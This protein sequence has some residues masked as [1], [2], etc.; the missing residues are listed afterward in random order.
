MRVDN[1]SS[2]PIIKIN[3]KNAYI[4]SNK[5]HTL[6]KS[7]HLNKKKELC[8]FGAKAWNWKY[9]KLHICEQWMWHSDINLQKGYK[10]LFV[11]THDHRIHIYIHKNVCPGRL[12]N[13]HQIP[14]KKGH[15]DHS[16]TKN[17]F[18][19]SKNFLAHRI[20]HLKI[21]LILNYFADLLFLALTTQICLEKIF[22]DPGLVIGS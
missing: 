9:R 15:L 17:F 21:R 3:L 10:S 14:L 1:S 5:K 16:A 20:E 12:S 6:N 22:S 18:L 7:I 2:N 13:P 11:L 4:H 19:E 8:I